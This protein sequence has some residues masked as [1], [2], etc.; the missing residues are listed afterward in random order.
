[1]A[2]A[3]A[4]I[5]DAVIAPAWPICAGDGP[6][7]GGGG[8]SSSTEAPV[9]TYGSPPDAYDAALALAGERG[10]VV[11]FGSLAFAAAVREH[12]LGIESD[13]IRLTLK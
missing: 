10:A 8:V 9:T 13:A 5:A 7:R 1:M 12:V 3:A 6:A 2:Q 11:A 4:P